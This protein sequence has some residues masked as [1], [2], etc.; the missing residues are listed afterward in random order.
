MIDLNIFDGDFIILWRSEFDYL[1]EGKI[2]AI[3][4]L[5]DEEGM[6]A[7]SLKRLVNE[8]P[9][10]SRRDDSKVEIGSENP[11]LALRSYNRKISPAV[12]EESGQFRVRGFY[13]R[14][15]H[16]DEI[17]LVDSDLLVRK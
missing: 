17:R 15:L 10:Y 11:V 3:E 9:R 4:R 1:G 13:R 7:W 8:S 16:P 6:G 14:T 12:L 2:V 5:G